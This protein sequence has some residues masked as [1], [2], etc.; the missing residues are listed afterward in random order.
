MRISAL[1]KKIFKFEAS[2]LVVIF[3]GLVCDEEDL[4]K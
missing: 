2:S 3:N 4:E 1:H